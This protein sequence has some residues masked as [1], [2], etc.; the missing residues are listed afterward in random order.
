MFFGTSQQVM[1][2]STNLALPVINKQRAGIARSKFSIT[3]VFSVESGEA[4]VTNGTNHVK[5]SPP[6]FTNL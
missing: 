3:H 6:F 5:Q 1:V 4:I 2:G